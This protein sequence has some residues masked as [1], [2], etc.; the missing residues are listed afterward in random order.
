MVTPELCRIR[1]AGFTLIELMVVLVVLALLAGLAAPVVTSSILRA[2]ESALK[3][4]L[5]T[6]RK[7][8]DDY[9]A[10]KGVYPESLETL[11]EEKYLRTLPVDPIAGK[12]EGWEFIESDQLET[13]GII[14]LKSVADIS[15]RD[16]TYYSDW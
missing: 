11:V 14:D 13:P 4:N 8:I 10:D 15:A 3:H 9:F 1:W 5:Y 2:K 6:T 7:A 16:G 12:G